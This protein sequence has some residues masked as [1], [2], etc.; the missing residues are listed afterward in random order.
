LLKDLAGEQ[1]LPHNE[2]ES[3]LNTEAQDVMALPA[4]RPLAVREAN[5]MALAVAAISAEEGRA[6]TNDAGNP[7]SAGSVPADGFVRIT[8]G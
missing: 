1:R 8:R 6:N 5:R 7:P 3:M 2:V 4:A